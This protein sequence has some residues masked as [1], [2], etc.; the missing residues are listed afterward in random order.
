MIRQRPAQAKTTPMMP[1]KIGSPRVCVPTVAGDISETLDR[2][3]VARNHVQ[4]LHLRL[5]SKVLHLAD[6]K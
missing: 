3:T 5:R 2:H 1:H 4:D 6:C